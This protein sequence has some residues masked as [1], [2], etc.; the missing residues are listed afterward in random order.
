VLNALSQFDRAALVDAT[1]CIAT[2]GAHLW[3]SEASRREIPA[4][5][6]TRHTSAVRFS[7]DARGSVVFVVSS[8]GTLSVFHGGQRIDAG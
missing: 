1:G 5:R 2:V 4:L 7:A 8:S 6:G 3:S